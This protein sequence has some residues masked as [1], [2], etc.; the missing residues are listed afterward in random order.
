MSVETSHWLLYG[1]SMQKWLSKHRQ[2][3]LFFGMLPLVVLLLIHASE[4]HLCGD[5]KA[6]FET[7]CQ[8]LS[9]NWPTPNGAPRTSIFF[10]AGV[11]I[12]FVLLYAGVAALLRIWRD[13]VGKEATVMLYSELL[14]DR[15][16][17]IK[18]AV[19]GVLS[20]IEG[21][22]NQEAASKAI[23]NAF[24]RGERDFLQQHLPFLAGSDAAAKNIIKA[25]NKPIAE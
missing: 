13:S 22:Q 4:N 7:C 24:E 15:D 16:L 10:A 21:R 19:K 17:A 18:N 3:L 6:W 9:G 2:R 25:L 11:T 20:M 23:D 14:K 1:S 5:A 8:F 12:R